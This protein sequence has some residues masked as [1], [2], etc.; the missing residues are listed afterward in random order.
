MNRD[1]GSADIV[2]RAV[3][4]DARCGCHGVLDDVPG[5]VVETVFDAYS[6]EL[7]FG[8]H[9][10]LVKLKSV[11]QRWGQVSE[12]GGRREIGIYVD[13]VGCGFVG[14]SAE[15]EGGRHEG[16]EVGESKELHLDESKR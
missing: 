11:S 6:V 7:W 2:G 8:G 1:E 3:G 5:V 13:V 10:A 4:N 15:T 14:S 16:K 9:G 12:Y